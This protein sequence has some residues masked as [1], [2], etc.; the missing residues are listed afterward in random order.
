MCRKT[1]PP[2]VGKNCN[3][4]VGNTARGRLNIEH[5][6]ESKALEREQAKCHKIRECKINSSRNNFISLGL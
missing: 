5:M 6:K 2:L 4:N 1:T 3:N